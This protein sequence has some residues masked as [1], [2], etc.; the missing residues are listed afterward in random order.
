MTSAVEFSV[1]K[2]DALI[3]PANPEPQARKRRESTTGFL[4]RKQVL[5]HD[6][7]CRHLAAKKI[8]WNCGAMVEESA[9]EKFRSRI[10]EFFLFE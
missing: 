7:F 2:T 1:V 3:Q 4:A 5:K 8:I 9:A 10:D 6:I